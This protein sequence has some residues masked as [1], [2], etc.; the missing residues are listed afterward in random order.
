MDFNQGQVGNRRCGDGGATLNTAIEKT[1]HLASQ[2][3]ICEKT[4]TNKKLVH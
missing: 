4:G 2:I 3:I 1:L